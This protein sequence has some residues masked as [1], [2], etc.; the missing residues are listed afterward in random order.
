MEQPENQAAARNGQYA[1]SVLNRAADIIEG[2]AK[3]GQQ[4]RLEDALKQAT[5]GAWRTP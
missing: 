1:H 2:A 3:A 5:N 4:W